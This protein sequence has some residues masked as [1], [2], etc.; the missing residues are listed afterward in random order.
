MGMFDNEKHSSKCSCMH[1]RGGHDTESLGI[2]NDNQVH[3]NVDV[4][5][6]VFEMEQVEAEDIL[7]AYLAEFLECETP[8]DVEELVA[9]FFDVV[10]SYTVQELYL[11]DIQAKIQVLNLLKEKNQ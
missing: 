2:E 10:A 5:E 8:E 7:K 4:D 3:Y 9:E 1:C 6:S 11:A